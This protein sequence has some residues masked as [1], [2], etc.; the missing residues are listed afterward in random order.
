MRNIILKSESYKT[1][2]VSR[3]NNYQLRQILTISDQVNQETLE[4]KAL[5]PFF[6]ACR[7]SWFGDLDE[8]EHQ[9]I[10]N[11]DI[12]EKIVKSIVN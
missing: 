10:P 8:K 2:N 12:I 1:R 9:Y 11:I 4:S 6:E 7:R 3:K 5:Q